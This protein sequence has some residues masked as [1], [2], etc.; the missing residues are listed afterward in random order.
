MRSKRDISRRHKDLALGRSS[1]QQVVRRED[2]RRSKAEE[3]LV[4]LRGRQPLNV[5]HIRL[6]T[7]QPREP[8][9]ML[10]DLQRQA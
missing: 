10:D 3:P 4:D 1:G 5:R 6:A 7:R 9:R 8:D 2:C